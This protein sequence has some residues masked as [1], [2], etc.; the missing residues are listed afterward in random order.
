VLRTDN[1]T[2]LALDQVHLGPVNADLFGLGFSEVRFDYDAPTGDWSAQGK[3][4]LFGTVAIDATP[5]PPNPPEY[6]VHFHGGDFKSAGAAADFGDSGITIFPGIQ[7]NR[8]GVAVSLNPTLFIGDIGLRAL[9]LGQIDGRVI[10][11]LPSDDAPYQ[12]TTGDAGPQFAQ[13]AGRTYTGSPTIGV[14]GSLALQI[15]GLDVPFG[16]A[17]FL[18]SYPSYVAFG[19][20]FQYGADD[21]GIDGGVNGEF[22]VAADQFNVEGHVQINLPD[23]LPGF[24]GDAVVSSKGIAACGHGTIYTPFPLTVTLGAGYHWGDGLAVWIKNCNIGEFVQQVQTSRARAADAARSFTLPAGLPSAEVRVDGTGAAPTVT[25]AGPGGE[26]AST[27]ASGVVSHGPFTLVRTTK[28]N[29]TWIEID[30]PRAGTYAVTTQQ[31]SAAIASLAV[32]N[33][34]P[35]ASVRARVTGSGAERSLHYRVLRR[36]GQEVAFM[37]GSHRIATVAGGS[38]TVR[39]VPL[40]GPLGMRTIV[41]QVTLAGLPNANITVAHFTV[42]RLPR[43]ARVGGLRVDRAGTVLRITWR[44]VSG[45]LRYAI[46]VHGT[47]G[48]LHALSVTATNRRALVRGIARSA[49]GD[50][51][52]TALRARDRGP[53]SSARF[54]ALVR[55]RTG[56]HARR[57]R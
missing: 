40:G 17:Y 41:A 35:P 8:V 4:D 24:R 19:G 1:Q 26:T 53:H 46:D 48:R 2:G 9:E 20:N 21:F 16:N 51:V 36:P 18:Y 25:V 33:G 49:G 11:A 5:D 34:L 39:F 54:R 32:A 13:I 38:G 56:V 28:L 45:A 31:G 44:G 55:L 6:G 57:R 47:D 22:N 50:V 10:V 29:A 3:L 23:P 14:G 52:V 42:R 30:H 37:E 43:L 12:L 27:D 7:L 15:A